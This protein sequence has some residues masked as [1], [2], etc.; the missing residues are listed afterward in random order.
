[1]NIPTLSLKHIDIS[2]FQYTILERD[3]HQCERC[4]ST[5][6]DGVSIMPYLKRE[7]MNKGDPNNYFCS[8]PQCIDILKWIY[9]TN[10]DG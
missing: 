3:M 10:K 7:D 1:M 4:L 9:N 6:M 2:D 5:L 8:C